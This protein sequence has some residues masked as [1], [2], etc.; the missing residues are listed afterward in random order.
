MPTLLYWTFTA[1]NEL[2]SLRKKIDEKISHVCQIW[3][4]RKEGDIISF[5][6]CQGCDNYVITA[7]SDG[8]VIGELYDKNKKEQQFK[9]Y[10]DNDKNETSIGR[11][12]YFIV[13]EF[14]KSSLTKDEGSLFLN[15]K[16][17]GI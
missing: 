3:D 11:E 5:V 9:I 13:P 1:P 8:K 14:N 12:C 6:T 17:F 4:V 7:K 15:L 10:N 2:I 16:I